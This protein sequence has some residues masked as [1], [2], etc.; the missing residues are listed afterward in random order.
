MGAPQCKICLHYFVANTDKCRC[1]T[2]PFFY[3]RITQVVN[4]LISLIADWKLIDK[5]ASSHKPKIIAS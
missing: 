3:I 1:S 2:Y 4:V 5:C